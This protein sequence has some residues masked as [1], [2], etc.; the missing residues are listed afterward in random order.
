ARVAELLAEQPA[1]VETSSPVALPAHGALAVEMRGV[2]FSYTGE[3]DV[4]HAVDLVV[5]AGRSLGLVGRTG[6]G[7]TTIGRLLLRL[8]D[9]GAGAVCLGGVDLRQTSHGDLRRRV[10]MVTQD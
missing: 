3:G 6:S 8:Y 7:K 9:P 4:L 2:S 10:R 1:L 5:P